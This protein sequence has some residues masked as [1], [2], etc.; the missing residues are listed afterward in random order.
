[1]SES[2]SGHE[3]DRQNPWPGLDSYSEAAQEYFY[4]RAAEIDELSRRVKGQNLTVLFGESGLG[5]TS[6]LQ[7][8]LFPKI[9]REAFLPVYVRLRFSASEQPLGTQV[10]EQLSGAIRAARLENTEPLENQASVWHWLHLRESELCDDFGRAVA[11]IFVFDQFEEI[12]TLGR[13]VPDLVARFV[14]ELGDW[15]RTACPL[16]SGKRSSAT[17]GRPLASIFSG[18]IPVC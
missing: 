6:L 10:K 9:R 15:P 8:G 3:L 18:P 7:A 11:P 12:F 4:G 16:N 13:A 5:K 17:R 1:M 2:I 14:T